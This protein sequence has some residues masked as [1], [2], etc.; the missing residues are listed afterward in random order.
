MLRANL[1]KVAHDLHTLMAD[2]DE[3]LRATAGAPGE[4]INAARVRAEESLR[5]I[6]ERIRA[7]EREVVDRARS[8]DRYVHENPWRSIATTGGIAFL[9]GLLISRR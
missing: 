4:K 9:L 3:L 2:A 6:R 5:N 7:A 1:N 8:A